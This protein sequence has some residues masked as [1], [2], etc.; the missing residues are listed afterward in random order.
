MEANLDL[1]AEQIDRAVSALARLKQDNHRLETRVRELQGVLGD[2]ERKLN[3]K[4]LQDVLGELD[5]LRTA[6]KAWAA[7]RKEIANRIEEL[8]RKLERL[9]A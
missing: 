1:L 2:G 9:E 6:E 3:G 4:K 8:A 5:G 7:E